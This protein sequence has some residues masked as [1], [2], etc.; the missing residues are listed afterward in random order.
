MT[1]K[2]GGAI[3]MGDLID[4]D[5]PEN[6]EPESKAPKLTYWAKKSNIAGDKEA[7]LK[8]FLVDAV[9]NCAA[10]PSSYSKMSV[11]QAQDSCMQELQKD[12]T[13]VGSLATQYGVKEN[14]LQADSRLRLREDGELEI[15]NMKQPFEQKLKNMLSPKSRPTDADYPANAELKSIITSDIWRS[16][17]QSEKEAAVAAI[18]EALQKRRQDIELMA[19]LEAPALSPSA[20]A[21]QCFCQKPGCNHDRVMPVSTS[22][23]V[24]VQGYEARGA[25]P[26]MLNHPARTDININ[27]ENAIDVRNQEDYETP[28]NPVNERRKIN[29]SKPPQPI[30]PKVAQPTKQPV[31]TKWFGPN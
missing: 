29:R 19:R 2:P 30:K 16:L 26:E 27:P 8:N 10:P 21:E 1:T 14:V 25:S 11:G 15:I 28:V 3:S 12:N 20:S 4:K 24:N 13:Q 6:L 9:S 23:P 31:S 17:T 22:A 18:N 5:K 7:T